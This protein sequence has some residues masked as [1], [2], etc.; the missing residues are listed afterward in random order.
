MSH[1]EASGR[2]RRLGL[3]SKVLGGANPRCPWAGVGTRK[4]ASVGGAL[5]SVAGL[6]FPAAAA[7]PDP[8]STDG[9]AVE[10]AA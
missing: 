3:A 5:A 4:P 2:P 6:C 8:N 9:S 7:R 10:R 1:L